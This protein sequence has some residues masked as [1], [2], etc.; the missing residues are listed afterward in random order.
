MGVGVQFS[1]RF[2]PERGEKGVLGGRVGAVVAWLGT[3]SPR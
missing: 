2:G 3:L 1:M